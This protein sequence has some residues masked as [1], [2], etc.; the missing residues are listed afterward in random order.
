MADAVAAL[1]RRGVGVVVMAFDE[2]EG[3]E[4]VVAEISA[5]CEALDRPWEVLIVDDGSRDGTGAVADRLA[6]ESERIRVVHHEQNQGLGGVY[7][8]GFAA[9]RA[10]FLTFFPADGQF[11]PEAIGRFAQRME[12]ADMVLGYYESRARGLTGRL[13]S[14]IE[15]LLYILLFGHMPRFRGV[16]MFRRSL[17]D[18]FPL[19]SEGRGWVVLMELI[20]RAHRGGCR[21]LTEPTGLRPRG[22]GRS[23][24]QNWR[25]I[26]ANLGQIVALRLVL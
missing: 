25:T 11:D 12:D 19:R 22:S 21:V 17:L 4:S 15:R 9:S 10:A 3:I 6:R 20:L 2:V 13:L 26:I 24:V 5:A 18:R 23:K 1:D 7:R 16:L 8:T 14:A